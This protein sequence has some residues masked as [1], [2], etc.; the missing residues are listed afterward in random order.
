MRELLLGLLGDQPVMEFLTAF[1]FAAF[2][3]ILSLFIHSTNRVPTSPNSPEKFSV[4][5]LFSDNFKRIVFNI[6]LI[7][8]IVRF[9]PQINGNGQ[10]LDE[11]SAFGCGLALDKIAEFLRNKTKTLEKKNDE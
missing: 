5:Y 11:W 1:F 10:A 3:A 6:L 9:Y 8:V 7:F 2:G 4:K